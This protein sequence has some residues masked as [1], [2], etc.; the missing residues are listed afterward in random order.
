MSQSLSQLLVHLVFSTKHR[1]PMLH[2]DIRDELHAYTI[3]ILR[4][5]E[6]PSIITNSVEDHGHILFSLSKNYA[7]AKIIEE[8]KKGTSKWLKTKGPSYASFY[9]QTGYGAFSVSPGDVEEVKRYIANQQEH[10]RTVSFQDELRALLRQYGI[11]FD[12]RY[13]WD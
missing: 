7:L 5:Y 3:G 9:W 11:E 4:H 12:E 6:S 8:V 10:H 13:L 2:D 1:V